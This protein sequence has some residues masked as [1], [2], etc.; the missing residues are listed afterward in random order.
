MTGAVTSA[1]LPTPNQSAAS[2]GGYIVQILRGAR[3]GRNTE[4]ENPGLNRLEP[5]GVWQ[6]ELRGRALKQPSALS[7][8]CVCV[9]RNRKQEIKQ[10]LFIFKLLNSAPSETPL[11]L[12]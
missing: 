4:N 3:R 1:P 12:A 8:L 11:L 7:Q 6:H 2:V 5:V 9:V 10:T